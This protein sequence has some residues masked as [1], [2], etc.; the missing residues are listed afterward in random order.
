MIHSPA[1]KWMLSGISKAFAMLSP[2]QGKI[3][4]ALL[5][6]APLYYLL[7]AEEFSCDLHVLKHAAS[8]HSEPGSNSPIKLLFL[9]P[10]LTPT[11][12]QLGL[13]F[14][15]YQF[16]KIKISAG[17]IRGFC[18]TIPVLSISPNFFK[19]MFI[20]TIAF[21]TRAVYHP[22]QPCQQNLL[23]FSAGETDQKAFPQKICA[24]YMPSIRLST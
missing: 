24:F 16:S 2:I 8:V 3:T 13:L 22:F 4:H 7:Q 14:R 10:T 20:R 1:D 23:I 17:I 9:K 21:K 15:H 5:T 6:R 19:S 11:Q 12:N 18:E